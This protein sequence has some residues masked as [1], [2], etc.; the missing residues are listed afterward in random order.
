M[1]NLMLTEVEK[2]CWKCLGKGVEITFAVPKTVGPEITTLTRSL[3][4]RTELFEA[5]VVRFFGMF[6]KRPHTCLNS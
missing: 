2:M 1:Y 6:L 3:Q 5:Y 4:I